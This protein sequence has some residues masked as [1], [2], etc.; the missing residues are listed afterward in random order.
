[1]RKGWAAEAAEWAAGNT[2]GTPHPTPPRRSHLML[3]RS[4]LMEWRSH[5]MGLPGY[6]A[7]PWPGDGAT[8]WPSGAA[9]EESGVGPAFRE[10][11][12][13]PFHYMGTP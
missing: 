5:L 12:G 4:H 13:R 1:M 11:P 8:P 6:W 10:P 2:I 7:F 3:W 9:G